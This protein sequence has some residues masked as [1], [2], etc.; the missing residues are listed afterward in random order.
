MAQNLAPP[1]RPTN[2]GPFSEQHGYADL[3][4]QTQTFNDDPTPL[5]PAGQQTNGKFRASAE[6]AMKSEKTKK[7]GNFLLAQ[8]KGFLL[9]R[10]T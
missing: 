8:L 1:E 3:K 7:A 4:I 6:A 10:C 2:P 9:G 5:N